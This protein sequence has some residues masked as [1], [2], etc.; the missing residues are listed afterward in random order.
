MNS[1]V[2][3]SLG[4]RHCRKIRMT[5]SKHHASAGAL[6]NANI[7][8][9]ARRW[10]RIMV[11]KSLLLQGVKQLLYVLP[12]WLAQHVVSAEL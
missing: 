11:D 2:S 3:L 10:C 4:R 1:H 6:V 9:N 7:Y 8:G 5:C 12:W